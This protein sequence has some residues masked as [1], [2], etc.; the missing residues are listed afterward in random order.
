MASGKNPGSYLTYFCY[1]EMCYSLILLWAFLTSNCCFKILLGKDGT[2]PLKL[3]KQ[4]LFL[5]TALSTDSNRQEW[6]CDALVMC[7]PQI[8]QEVTGW[9]REKD[10]EKKLQVLANCVVI[11]KL[12]YNTCLFFPPFFSFHSFFTKILV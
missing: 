8:H 2:S 4:I 7:R 9:Q 5:P 12:Q 1:I 11:G 3:I 6:S 10:E